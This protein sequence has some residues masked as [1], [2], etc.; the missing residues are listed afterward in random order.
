MTNLGL[1]SLGR[2]LCSSFDFFLGLLGV[3]L[4]SSGM[5]S[6]VMEG[7]IKASTVVVHQATDTCTHK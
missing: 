7:S 4:S 6:R 5:S 1:T 2:L 3:Q